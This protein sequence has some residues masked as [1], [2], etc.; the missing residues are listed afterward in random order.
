LNN[1]ICGIQNV[2]AKGKVDEGVDRTRRTLSEMEVKKTTG[3][4]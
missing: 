2:I 1:F 3:K 4:K